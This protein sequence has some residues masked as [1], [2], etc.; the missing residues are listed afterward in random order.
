MITEVEK[1]KYVSK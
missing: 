1:R